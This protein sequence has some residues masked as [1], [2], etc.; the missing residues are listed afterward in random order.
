[1]RR[2]IISAILLVGLLFS[3]AACQPAPEKEVVVSK[4]DGAFEQAITTDAG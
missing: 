3:L 1:M 2:K 4:N